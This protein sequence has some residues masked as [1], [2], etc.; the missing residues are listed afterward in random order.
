MPARTQLL[1]QIFSIKSDGAFAATAMAV[2]DFQI[3]NNPVY[4]AYSEHIGIR[5][6]NGFAF[7]PIRFF[8]SHRVSCHSSEEMVFTSSGTTGQQASRHYVYDLEVY[9]Q[10]FLKGF[11]LAHGNAFNYCFLALLPSYLDRQGS[12]LVFMAQELIQKSRHDE[13]GFFLNEYDTLLKRLKSLKARNVPTILLGV[14]FALL[15]FSAHY[16]IAFPQ[17]SVMETGGMKGRG[18]ELVREEL[19]QVL[20]EAFHVEAIHSEYGMT[21]LLSQAYARADGIFRCPPWMRVTA[22]DISDPLSPLPPGRRGRLAIIDLANIDSCAF[23]ATDD[24]GVVRSDGSFTV[25][26]RIDHSDVRG[27][28]L[29]YN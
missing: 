19:H 15:D 8:K 13:S 23:I 21:E 1:R 29:L 7:L 25:E 14:S 18:R 6:E 24:I 9:R 28:N 4:Q 2:R 3:K 27:C 16:E 26:G 12:S 17:L 22:L 11:T 20:K 10:S 5:A